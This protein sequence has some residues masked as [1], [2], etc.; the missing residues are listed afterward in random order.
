M[1]LKPRD[2]LKRVLENGQPVY[3]VGP[4]GLY[5]KVRRRPAVFTD[6]ELAVRALEQNGYGEVRA[7]DLRQTVLQLYG[8]G[9]DLCVIHG[10]DQSTEQFRSVTMRPKQSALEFVKYLE[11]CYGGPQLSDSFDSENNI[12]LLPK[13]TRIRSE[14][15]VYREAYTQPKPMPAPFSV[16]I[17]GFMFLFHLF[18]QSE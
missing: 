14:Y 12:V 7:L 11:R 3:T 8:S 2:V 16:Y 18:F 6:R 1:V 9:L 13:P 5:L 4:T 10:Y 15:E 17:Y